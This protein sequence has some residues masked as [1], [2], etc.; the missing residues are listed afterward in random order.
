MT[1][2]PDLEPLRGRPGVI[3]LHGHRGAR[4]LMPENTLPGFAFAL[5]C[6]VEILEC[7]V[8]FSRE[9]TP[10]VTH[11]PR[12]SP[13]M[14]RD[15]EGGWV[16][17]PGPLV[18]ALSLE[19][20]RRFDAGGLRSGSAY[21]ARWPDQ[22]F[23][24]GV[25]V[26]CLDELAA[27]LARPGHGR[28]WLNLEIKSSPLHPE[29][30]PP[31]P[32]QVAAVLA[33]LDDY[34]LAGRTLVQSFDWRV[35]A[36]LRRQRPSIPRSFLSEL[37]GEG[38]TPE[39]NIHDGSPWMAGLSLAAHG[40]SLPALV[41]A[42]GGQAWSP[43][44]GDLTAEDLARARALGL[45]VNVWTVNRPQDIDRMIA[46]GVDGI[47]TDFPGRVQHRLKAQGMSWR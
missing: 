31:P 41:A 34:G 44:F 18:R 17:A 33:V 22:A 29:H 35:L 30:G 25:P 14:T 11:N 7:D 13:D 43:H 23:L 32:E 45:I 37:S 28:V 38:A 27:L 40:G 36:E 26:P 1:A 19:E 4:G 2:A 47:I 10:V 21:A 46:L 8:L 9:G 15:A 24:S 6:G 42:A 3:R 39:A 16:A 5:A 20:L 12:L